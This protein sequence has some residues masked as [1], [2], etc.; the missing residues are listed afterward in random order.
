MRTPAHT[1]YVV[2]HGENPANLTREFSYKLIDYSLTEKGILQS[3][4]T[5][6][7]LRDLGIH[8]VYSSPLKRALETALIIAAPL[9]LPV[10]TLEAFRE[11]NVG[12]LEG[13]PPSDENW[14]L[15]DRII[16]DWYAGRHDVAFP[17]GE[18]FRTQLAR[19]KHGLTAILAT[20]T[21]TDPGT[22]NATDAANVTDAAG[23]RRI[24][25]VAHG[26]II[27][28][29][30]RGLATGPDLGPTGAKGCPNCSVT[31][32]SA[33]LIDGELELHLREWAASDHLS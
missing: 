12:D 28:G 8:A 5:A 19:V 26:G 4:Q 17:G 11:N 24:V 25:L 7:R 13:Q 21:D 10:A 15:H 14:A 32:F 30:A 6:I 16:A 33:R 22:A 23:E 3:E 29:M 31:E 9:G 18:D 20:D 2:R 1:L 27:S